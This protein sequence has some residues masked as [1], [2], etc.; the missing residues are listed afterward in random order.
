MIATSVVR[1]FEGESKTMAPNFTNT[2]PPGNTPSSIQWESKID[3]LEHT[4]AA[5][6]QKL[7]AVEVPQITI[8]APRSFTIKVTA[9]DIVAFAIAIS[10]TS[11]G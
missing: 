11:E 1:D 4:L 9:R 3:G 5:V 6:L 10:S 7:P 8:A 2:N